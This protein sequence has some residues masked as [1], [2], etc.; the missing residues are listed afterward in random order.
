MKEIS[1]V[2]VG[3][4]PSLEDVFELEP[5]RDDVSIEMVRPVMVPSGDHSRSNLRLRDDSVLG[6]ESLLSND[7]VRRVSCC[8]ISSSC[9]VDA[10]HDSFDEYAL[11]RPIFIPSPSDLEGLKNHHIYLSNPWDAGSC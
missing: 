6:F 3:Y 11:L 7:S 9:N 2:Q 1:R 10:R 5:T 8:E 4:L